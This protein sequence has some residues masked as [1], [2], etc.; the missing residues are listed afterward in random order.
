MTARL[1]LILKTGAHKS[2]RTCSF[3]KLFLGE[4]PLPPGEGGRRPGES[5]QPKRFVIR[6]L[7][8]AL[9][10]VPLPEGEGCLFGCG[11]AS[12]SSC[13]PSPCVALLPPRRKN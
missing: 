9:R 1:L 2:A 6:A 12:C 8:L 5:T 11:F 10:G 3:C 4:G 13:I 7:T